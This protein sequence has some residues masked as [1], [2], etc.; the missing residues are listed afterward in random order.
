MDERGRT[1]RAGAPRSDGAGGEAR[2]LIYFILFD[3]NSHTKTEHIN[4]RLAPTRAG[5][6]L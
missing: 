2:G 6:N 3:L 4:N 5:L 1:R